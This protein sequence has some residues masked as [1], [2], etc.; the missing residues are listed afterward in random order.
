MAASD[1]P[2]VAERSRSWPK[3]L[4]SF[5]VF[6]PSLTEFSG[7]LLGV[8]GDVQHVCFDKI[9]FGV[10]SM[11][12]V[13]ICNLIRLRPPCPPRMSILNCK[14][15]MAPCMAKY[16]FTAPPSLCGDGMSCSIRN[17]SNRLRAVN[18]LA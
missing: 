13:I 17:Y 18:T 15:A 16:Y 11:A 10:I 3:P 4:L 12:D 8:Q 14:V 9:A 2:S 5:K 1:V 7:D 6:I